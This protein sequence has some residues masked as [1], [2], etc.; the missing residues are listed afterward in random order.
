MKATSVRAAK[1]SPK[2]SPSSFPAIALK[3]LDSSVGTPLE[4]ISTISSFSSLG[5]PSWWTAWT[6]RIRQKAGVPSCGYICLADTQ[7]SVPVMMMVSVV[8]LDFVGDPQESSTMPWKWSPALATACM[9]SCGL[10]C[11]RL[12]EADADRCV[13]EFG[14]MTRSAATKC[15]IRSHYKFEADAVVPRDPYIPH[16]RLTGPREGLARSEFITIVQSAYQESALILFK[17]VVNK[18]DLVYRQVE[19]HIGNSA[20]RRFVPF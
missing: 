17:N 19:A 4:G 16:Q 10:R 3:K 1:G 11:S 14:T 6:M 18:S 8:G 20:P 12:R 9:V 2:F 7:P 15:C 13:K 5:F